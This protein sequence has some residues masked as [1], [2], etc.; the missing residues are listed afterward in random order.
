MAR[1]VTTRLRTA[2]R[3]TGDRAVVLGAG[4][5]GAGNAGVAAST[6]HANA[7]DTKRMAI[8]S[9]RCRREVTEETGWRFLGVLNSFLFL[10]TNFYL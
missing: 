7:A 2:G 10:T 5:A 9:L 4:A 3:F 1:V 6:V 8:E